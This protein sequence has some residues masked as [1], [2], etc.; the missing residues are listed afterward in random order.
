MGEQADAVAELEHEVRPRLEVGVAATNVDHHRGLVAGQ[1]EVAEHPAHHGWPGREDS[2]VVEVAAVVGEAARRRLAE[3]VCSLIEQRRR[4]GDDEQH[5][6]LGHDAVGRRGLVL[7]VA[8][9]RHD[10]HFRRE[11][12]HQF[13]QALAE[14]RRVVAGRLRVIPCPAPTGTSILGFRK[15]N[16]RYSRRMGP[17]T[18]NGY[19][20]E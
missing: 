7:T 9:Q 8:A 12:G 6:T 16:V 4:G 13:A 2:Q 14:K 11:R 19:A 17:A 15:K 10:L 20:T 3:S 1:V 18:P 5:V